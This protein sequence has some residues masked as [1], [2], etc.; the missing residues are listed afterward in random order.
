CLRSRSFLEQLAHLLAQAR[1]HPAAC[2]VDGAD[3]QSQPA[4]GFR[5]RMGLDDAEPEGAPGRVVELL[6]YL[7][8]RPLEEP[9]LV[10]LVP[11]RRFLLDRALV[12]EL[13]ALTFQDLTRALSA[14]E[15]GVELVPRD[16]EEPAAEGTA[17]GVIIKGRPNA[18]DG[19]EDLLREV[20]RVAV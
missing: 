1:H 18:G 3:R 4:G 17:F 13:L 7:F 6:A 2:D 9:L 19:L 20:G 8:G 5:G 12:E 14:G 15:E 11:D 10:F 16:G